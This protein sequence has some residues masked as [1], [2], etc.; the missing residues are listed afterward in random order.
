MPPSPAR[1]RLLVRLLLVGAV[2]LAFAPALHGEWLNWDDNINFMQNP[3]FRG[4]GWEQLRWMWTD[5]AGV[6]V[7]LAWMSLGLNFLS[8]GMDPRGYHALNV[9]LHAVSA[10]GLWS[11]LEA[12]LA[13]TAP[14][15]A[16]GDRRWAAVAGALFW[17]LHPLRVESV[18]WITERRDVLCTALLFPA[19]TLY[20]RA[21]SAQGRRRGWLLAASCALTLASMLAKAHAMT[22]AAVLL[23]LDL[24]VL[25]RWPRERFGR[26]LLEKVPWLLLGAGMALVAAGSQ[27]S[28]GAAASF[29]SHGPAA[30]AAVIAEGLRYYALQT[31]APVVLTPIQPLL[32]PIH[33]QEHLL[34]GAVA[35][36]GALG[37]LTLLVVRR[38]R[39]AA[40]LLL[41]AVLLA[42]VSGVL[43]SSPNL[44]ADRNSLVATVP[45]VAL[46]AA[47]A[48]WALP[49]RRG[50]T[51]ALL[52]AW[53]GALGAVTFG[54]AEA[55]SHPLKLWALQLERFP[56]HPQSHFLM[57]QSL[58]EAGR[59]AEAIPAYQAALRFGHPA[60]DQVRLALGHCQA[61]VG[62]FDEALPTW[63]RIPP[64]SPHYAEAQ[65]FTGRALWSLGRRGEALEAF[66]RAAA[67]APGD[68]EYAELLR[69][70]RE[71][72]GAL[73]R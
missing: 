53:L 1:A 58:D 48:A 72:G 18:V 68:A 3:H 59:D 56:E 7:P 63:A 73:E 43:Q 40:A 37:T 19:V 25:D 46:F 10:L 57:A 69:R 64:D 51:I 66:S 62:S 15:V 33:P 60:P 5:T 42:P 13:R 29:A 47:A 21:V 4:L 14:G 2:F 45:F 24:L 65:A 41:Y 26:L 52:V 39:L 67:A 44:V 36:A 32:L 38:R 20:I 28:G 50:L 6:Y 8:G 22:F 71:A 11:L 70:A 34:A 16:P 12:L 55:W 31:L 54:Y 49:R 30:R 23:V 27:V 61:D 9:A 35:L 17:A